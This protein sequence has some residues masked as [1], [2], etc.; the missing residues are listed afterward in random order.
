MIDHTAVDVSDDEVAKSFHSMAV[1]E[2]VCQA[3]R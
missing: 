2:S 3:P 1:V